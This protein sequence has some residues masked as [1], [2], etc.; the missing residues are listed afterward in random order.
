VE[1]SG[2][3]SG[4]HV[5][6]WPAKRVLEQDLIANA[7]SEGVGLY[8]ISHCYLKKSSRTGVMLGYSTLNEE[9]IRQG[10]RLLSKVL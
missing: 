1:V 9:E 6:L 3:G 2:D 7:A 8:P 10:I 5:V 4:T